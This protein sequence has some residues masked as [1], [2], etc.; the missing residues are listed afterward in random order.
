MHER[1][2]RLCLNWLLDI[3]C[4][5]TESVKLF[6]YMPQ[7]AYTIEQIGMHLITANHNEPAGHFTKPPPARQTPLRMTSCAAFR[8]SCGSMVNKS[9]TEIGRESGRSWR[10]AFESVVPS[11][12]FRLGRKDLPPNTGNKISA[13]QYIFPVCMEIPWPLHG[14]ARLHDDLRPVS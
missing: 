6:L 8:K 9:L 13:R 4:L 12:T 11:Q 14:D 10:G 1:L 2:T 7:S 5:T 3:L